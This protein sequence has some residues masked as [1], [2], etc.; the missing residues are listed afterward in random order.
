MLT[1]AGLLNLLD[2][3]KEAIERD[4]EF[5]QLRY[6]KKP[7]PNEEYENG[8]EYMVHAQIRGFVESDPDKEVKIAAV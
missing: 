8:E 5:G 3:T 2:R 7:Y 1:K 6:E 4:S